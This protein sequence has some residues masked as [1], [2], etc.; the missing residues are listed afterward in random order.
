MD[1]NHTSLLVFD[2][3]SFEWKKN[4]NALIAKSDNLKVITGLSDVSS[5][6][7]KPLETYKR[8]ETFFVYNRQ[9]GVMK[10][11][12]MDFVISGF[13]S[14]IVHYIQ[15]EGG[16]VCEIEENLLKK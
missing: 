4:Q 10:Q 2:I 16:V 7:I 5:P 9:T 15:K 3:F 11:F 8:P 1:I 6:Q 13:Y 12:H 14:N